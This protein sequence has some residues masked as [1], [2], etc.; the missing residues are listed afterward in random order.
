VSEKIVGR[1]HQQPR[2]TPCGCTLEH[3]RDEVE[4][5]ATPVWELFAAN[6]E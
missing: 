5:V 6:P 3:E 2:S 4:E 1:K